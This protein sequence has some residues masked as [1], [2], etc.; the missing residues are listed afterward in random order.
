ALKNLQSNL[1]HLT[2]VTQMIAKGDFTKRVDFLYDFS[3]AFN[4]MV[5]DLDET[6]KAL[7]IQ[8]DELQKAIT[9]LFINKEQYKSL[10]QKAPI[11]I[12]VLKNGQIVLSNPAFIEMLHVSAREQV[13]DQSFLQFIR[14]SNRVTFL[15]KMARYS[16]YGVNWNRFEE[17]LVCIDN[18]EI[19][20]KMI[21]TD[22]VFENDPATLLFIDDITRKKKEETRIINS[23]QEKDILLKEVYH[24]VKNNMQI[25]WSLLSMQAKMVQDDTIKGYFVDCQNRVKS[26]A[27]VHE[28][29]YKTDNLREINY[30]HYLKKITSHLFDTYNL[31]INN[32]HLQ[33]ES[34]DE[35]ITLAK[36]VPCSLIVNELISNSLKYAFTPEE[37]GLITIRFGSYGT[38]GDY[39]LDYRDNGQGIPREIQPEQSNTL[40]MKLI[41]GLTRQLHG[42]VFF[43]NDNGV[44]YVIRFP[45]IS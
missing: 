19:I 1:R 28:Q 30:G 10:I 8:T 45:S 18:S 5:S 35:T 17:E 39:I 6:K 21:G 16:E 36:A 22:I 31:N 13:D 7:T 4:S 15:H 20:T 33:I 25:I 32:V 40:G 44:H 37:K 27:L 9:S 24:R 11:S 42:S 26:L 43:E 29:L 38:Q 12:C 2:W 23:L 41:Y 3:E 34:G 14:P